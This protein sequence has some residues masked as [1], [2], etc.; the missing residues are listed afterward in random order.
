MLQEIDALGKKPTDREYGRGGSRSVADDEPGESQHDGARRRHGGVERSPDV[1]LVVPEQNMG[2]RIKYGAMSTV[3]T[4]RGTTIDYET[5]RDFRAAAGRYFTREE[6][7]KSAR[8]ALLGD[9][10]R[11][12]LFRDEDP[13]GKTVLV[14]KTLFQVIGVLEKKEPLSMDSPRKTTRS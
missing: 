8:V 5:V 13:I 10:V 1:A 6:D 9:R 3:A 2:R 14:G 4:V 7:H 11:E 12:I